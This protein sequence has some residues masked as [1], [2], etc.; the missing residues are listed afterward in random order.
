M[1]R[2]PVGRKKKHLVAPTSFTTKVKQCRLLNND[3]ACNEWILW[4][5]TYLRIL[6]TIQNEQKHIR[7]L[8]HSSSCLIDVGNVIIDCVLKHGRSKSASS[9][10]MLSRYIKFLEPVFYAD[11]DFNACLVYETK[12]FSLSVPEVQRLIYLFRYKSHIM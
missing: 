3:N 10:V 7:N 2:T 9:A 12:C 11:S 4:T 6:Y 8:I 1:S 5:S